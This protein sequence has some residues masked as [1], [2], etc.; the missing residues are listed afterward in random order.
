MAT[1]TEQAYQA[2]EATADALGR[3][4][5]FASFTGGAWSCGEVEALAHVLRAFGMDEAAEALTADDS[6]HVASDEE[7]DDHYREDNA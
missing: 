4:Y 5:D 1:A 6:T 7:G 2:D 3:L